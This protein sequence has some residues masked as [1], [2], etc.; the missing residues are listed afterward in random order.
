MSLMKKV[1]NKINKITIFSTNFQLFK[2]PAYQTLSS[3]IDKSK[4][5]PQPSNGGFSSDALKTLWAIEINWLTQESLGL[6]TDHVQLRRL[7]SIINSKIG[8]NTI[9]SKTL[10]YISS[11]DTERWLL[12]SCLLFLWTGTTFPSNFLEK[13]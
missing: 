7:F 10:E 4:K 13:F 1:L 3:V 5:A 2:R 11:K 8:S 9:F 6:K 12:T